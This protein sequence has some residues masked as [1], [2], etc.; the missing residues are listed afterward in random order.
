MLDKKDFS[1]IESLIQKNI[2]NALQEFFE[3][4]ILPYFEHNEEDHKEIRK[5]LSEHDKRF[6]SVDIEL[7]SMQRKLEKNEDDHEEIFRL[8]DKNEKDHKKI[9]SKFRKNT[10]E[11]GQISEKINN[12]E[13]N[14]IVHEKRIRRIE[15]VVSS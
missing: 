12:F 15:A 8:L 13:S 1:T 6:D 3:T 9:F 4:L 14:Y 7:D 10:K 2:K 5:T 11:H